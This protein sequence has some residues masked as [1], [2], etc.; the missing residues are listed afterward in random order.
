MR[1]P[2][3][4]EQIEL[5]EKIA[6]LVEE[7]GWNQEDF[8]RYTDLNRQTVRQILLHGR[9]RLRNATICRCAKALGLHVNDLRTQPLERLLSRINGQA[10]AADK[11]VRRLYEQATQP[12]LLAWLERNPERAAQLTPAEIDE[13]LSLQGTG[14]PLTRHG[15]EHYVTLIE[16]K[17]RLIEQIQ[18]I[19]GTEF[20]ELLEK[21][22]GLIHEKVQ[23]Y[24][25]RR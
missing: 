10:A 16:R 21:L 2:P 9:R 1:G 20:F 12:E 5:A 15:V 17:R 18:S 13:L 4:P 23:P 25:D 22:V 8:A 11:P 3:S 24:A 14:G 6:R 7:R 19:A